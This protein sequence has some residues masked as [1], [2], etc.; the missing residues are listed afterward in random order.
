MENYFYFLEFPNSK[1]IINFREITTEE[2]LAIGKANY[3]FD[4]DLSGYYDFIYNIF[5][6]CVSNKDVYDELNILEFLMF[7]LKI[8]TISVGKE[9]SVKTR[10][11]EDVVSI[12]IDLFKLL[13]NTVSVL[14]VVK[15]KI[16]QDSNTKMEIWYPL[17]SKFSEYFKN[18]NYYLFLD[19]I[20]IGKKFYT[21]K[22]NNEKFEVFKKL[23]AKYTTFLLSKVYD[24]IKENSEINIFQI[25]KLKNLKIDFYNRAIPIFEIVRLIN[26]YDI[27]NIHQEIY[28]L[29]KLNPFY[30]RSITP[31]ERK[32][33]ISM[34]IEELK[35]N[36]TKI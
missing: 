10:I 16:F 2:Q 1:K 7:L 32:I 36:T 26:V 30:V 20:Q 21:L 5:R 31:S 23:P 18:Q 25:D 11:D 34:L 22:D 15:P 27:K 29:S 4:S 12:N 33:Y 14:D 19:K 24:F 3:T 9:F 8:R 28:Q 17:A 13:K 35:S 6:N